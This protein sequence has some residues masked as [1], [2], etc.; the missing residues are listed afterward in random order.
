MRAI[1]E[2]HYRLLSL[3]LILGG[4]AMYAVFSLD[5]L[6]WADEAYTF[7]MLRHSFAE[8]WAITAADVHPPLYYFLLKLL[9]APFAYNLWAVRFFSALPC[10]ILLVTAAF[11]L[12]K[13][14]GKGA[15]ALFLLLYLLYP[16]TMTYAA[17]ARM[18][19]L[20]ELF[21]FLNALFAYRCWKWNLGR[22]WAGFALSGVCAAYTH[23]FAL[24]SAGVIYLIL[25][26]S[27]AAKKR[28]LL[29]RWLL[30][31]VATIL[32]YLPWL[33]CFLTQLA[34]KIDNPYWIEP[35]T[36]GTLV[37]YVRAIL[38]ANGVVLFP[39]FAGAAF[40]AA[41]L[42]MLAARDRD[43]L[44]ICLLALAVPLGTV[45]IGLAASLLVRPVFVIRY[46]LPSLPLAVFALALMLSRTK[47]QTLFAAVIT[48]VLIGGVSN[49]AYTAKHALI[50]SEGRVTNT[51]VSALPE[52][53]AYVVLSRYTSH[54]SQE[55]AY[56][57]PETPIFTSDPLGM[58]NPYANRIPLEE[59]RAEDFP[60]IIL[61]LEK[62]VEFP[63]ELEAIY[64]AELVCTATVTGTPQYFW[65]LTALPG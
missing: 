54:P 50:P 20:A 52:H 27:A 35:I 65:Y 62:D 15:A 4:A 43:G 18:Y 19:S 33:G 58:D 10:L 26:V 3:L 6:V 61:V 34:Y 46:L 40:L 36:P 7:A 28:I 48:V 17:E 11:Q 30:A 24:V 32:L 25:F 12:P 57:D 55:L 63:E 49:A 22:D 64:S 31:A 9:S 16:Y 14:F 47:E 1:I 41:L 2:K 39:L 51:L 60:K 59:F 23:Y 38:S 21:I 42:S 29:K 53:D 37:G 5:Q 45:V 44:R 13:L 56:Y 8:I